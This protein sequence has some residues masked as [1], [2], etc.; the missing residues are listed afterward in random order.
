MILR[1]IFIFVFIMY[2]S[3]SYGQSEII[4]FESLGIEDGLSQGSVISILKDSRG[5]MWFGTQGGLNRYDGY[6]FKIFAT[7]AD[8]TTLSSNFVTSLSEDKNGNIWIGT[9]NG[10]N[11]LKIRTNKI[12][13]FSTLNNEKIKLVNVLYKDNDQN[14]FIG[15][16][17]GIAKIIIDEKNNEYFELEENIDPR[18]KEVKGKN[19]E[20]IHRDKKGNLW[21]GTKHNGLYLF[22]AN[23]LDNNNE[24]KHY[25]SGNGIQNI[26]YNH[27]ISIASDPFGNV[28]VG[29]DNGLNK[30]NLNDDSIKKYYSNK[31]DLKTISGNKI[32]CVYYGNSNGFWVGT[33]ENGISKYNYTNDT[34]EGFKNDPNDGNSLSDNNWV[35]SIYE[36]DTGI[37]WIGTLLGGVNKYE[38]FKSKFTHYRGDKNNPN[39]FRKNGV[40]AICEDNNEK[41]IWIGTINNGL[42]YYDKQTRLFTHYSHDPNNVN[43]LQDNQ[44]RSVTQDNNGSIWI[45]FRKKGVCRIDF[46][47][48][49]QKYTRYEND[50]DDPSSFPYNQ[51]SKIIK[52][53]QGNIWPLF[54]NGALCKYNPIA[55]KFDTYLEATIDQEGVRAPTSSVDSKGQIWIGSFKDLVCYD[56]ITKQII[57]SYEHEFEKPNSLPPGVLRCITESSKLGTFWI[58]TN[59]GLSKF[60]SNRDTFVL[61]TVED[62]LADNTVYSAI[63][64]K[65]GKV[66]MSTNKGVSAF[67]PFT[68][69][70]EN[71]DVSDGLQSNEFNN[72]AYFISKSGEIFFGGVNGVNSFY[73]DQIRYNTYVPNIVLTDL[74]FFNKVGAVTSASKSYPQMEKDIS[75]IDSLKI[76]YDNHVIE[77]KFAALHYT[78]PSKNKYAYQ[79]VGFSNEWTYTDAT[80]R[81]ITYTNL[82][83][84]EYTLKIKASNNDGFWNEEGISIYIYIVP[85]F[86]MTVWF[87]LLM[88]FLLVLVI[89]FG[90]KLGLRSLRNQKTKL[91]FLVNNRTKQILTHKHEIEEQAKKLKIANKE[92]TEINKEVEKANIVIQKKNDELYKINNSLEQKVEERTRELKEVVE[93]LDQFIHRTSHDLRG[94]ISSIMGL[95]FIVHKEIKDE[96][97]LFYFDIY[98]KQIKKIDKIIT[99]ILELTKVKDWETK[100]VK[101][102]FDTIVEGCISSF[103]YLPEFDKIDFLINIQ[104]NIGFYSDENLINSILQNLIENAIKYSNQ[105]GSPFVKID[106]TK[107]K[108]NIKIKVSDNGIG[109]DKKYHKKIFDM[110][111]RA[112]TESQGSGLGMHI[113]KKAVTKLNGN[114]KL[115]SKINEG[116][117]FEVILPAEKK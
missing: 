73:S 96:S 16:Q 102:D 19:I 21:V 48:L 115:K 117:T 70:F 12:E 33:F 82:D 91:E 94:P 68:K 97:S 108:D 62:G 69:T 38:H 55:D 46:I 37:L 29:T 51:V 40:R 17:D 5:F 44:I 63:E 27:I 101:I 72:N 52:D 34:F 1:V 78:E 104:K 88:F 28:W 7:S 93:E 42:Y 4:Q 35:K 13:R 53:K 24:F 49:K 98:H 6:E 20:A 41:G 76:H 114:I 84:G 22:Y 59:R 77:F 50:P 86:W 56:P 85:N 87:K 54:Y 99:D 105:E 47:G 92:I 74:N 32:A 57:K 89:L 110:F 64:D 116:S 106:I 100:K 2:V 113:F 65:K 71:F 11:K 95:D 43:S 15:H 14:I 8:T 39:L 31:N 18:F 30:I 58:G 107:N 26:S 111:F 23:S 45:G 9:F 67:D 83:P 79:L 60:D 66:W 36:D 10:L 112:T 3:F 81:H 61:Y 103:N 25:T 90:I 75:Q 109:I 80:N